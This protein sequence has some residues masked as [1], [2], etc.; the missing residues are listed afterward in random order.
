MAFEGLTEKLQHIFSKLTNRGKLTEVEVKAAMREIKLVLLE[1]DVNFKV[2]K[3]FIQDIT[4]RA[5]GEEV[6]KSLTPGQ[7]VVKIVRDELVKIL[8]EKTVGVNFASNPPTIIMMC[9]LQ[10]SGKT[11]MCGKL[12]K[13][14][15]KTGKSVMLA[16]LDIYRPAAIKQLEVVAGNAGAAFFERGQQD[17][18]LTAKQALAEAHKKLSDVLIFDTAGRLHIDSDMMEELKRIDAEVKPHEKLLVVDAMTG[19]DA[20]NAATAFN[21]SL[22]LDGIILTKLDGDTRGGAAI[23]VK[24]VTGKPIKFAGI[25]EKLD[26]IEVFHPDRMAG[27]ILGMGDVLTLIE[28]AEQNFEEEKVAALEKK[29]RKA[30]FTLEDFLEQMEQIKHMGNLGDMLSMLPGGNKFSG[31]QPDEKQMAR[32]EAIIKSM[33]PGERRNPA[34]IGGSRK[35]RISKGSGTQVQDVNRL[36]SQFEQMTKLMKTMSKRGKGGMMR[37]PF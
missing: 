22:E 19:Q 13:M 17:P 15:G 12:A 9:G 35:K 10:G 24:A 27:R 25:G 16:A 3:S 6:L 20:V 4:D 29:L 21:E 7:Q 1:A 34:V 37:M 5:V 26:D 30:E 36:L 28:K 14:W 32:T 18:V 8:G 31:F 2:V 33:T 11:T 23:S